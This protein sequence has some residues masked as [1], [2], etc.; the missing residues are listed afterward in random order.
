MLAIFRS[1]SPSAF[2]FLFALSPSLTFSSFHLFRI[3]IHLPFLTLL[4]KQT[5]RLIF[6]TSQEEEI[7]T[8]LMKPPCANLLSKERKRLRDQ[9]KQGLI[10]CQWK[11]LKGNMR[12]VNG[13]TQ[14]PWKEGKAVNLKQLLHI[15][16]SI[17]KSLRDLQLRECHFSQNFLEHFHMKDFVSVHF[18]SHIYSTIDIQ[19]LQNAV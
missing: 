5:T 16:L 10:Q 11:G 17:C 13:R 2:C 12:A 14:M 18:I 3:F 6:Y 8:L 4:P 7:K 1:P 9:I 15:W 19:I